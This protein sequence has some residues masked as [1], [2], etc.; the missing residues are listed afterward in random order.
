MVNIEDYNSIFNDNVNIDF[1]T[2]NEYA[3]VNNLYSSYNTTYAALTA[4]L[5]SDYML[6]TN[7]EYTNYDHFFPNIVNTKEKIKLN[8]LNFIN[9]TDYRLIHFGN[10]FYP[11]ETSPY[12]YG[13]I[14]TK[15]NF[16][17][18]LFN[19]TFFFLFEKSYLDGI[20]KKIFHKKLSQVIKKNVNFDSDDAIENL[21]FLLVNSDNKFKKTLFLVH[22]LYPHHPYVYNKKCEKKKPA[23]GNYKINYKCTLLKIKDL[24]NFLKKNDP[25]S[26]VIFISDHGLKLQVIEKKKNQTNYQVGLENFL[27][28]KKTKYEF[29]SFNLFNVPKDYRK[30]LKRNL[31]TV[32]LSRL[33][34]SIINQTE[35]EF[36]PTK[37]FLLGYPGEKR[38]GKV[39]RVYFK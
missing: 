11:D 2:N 36:E 34:I 28:D 14:N 12:S 4:F 30:F 19:K 29:S 25:N 20:Y 17:N 27:I 32:N 18:K 38:F 31:D 39:E 1:L 33:I 22:H 16:S 23:T 9:K 5:T 21:K 13:V 24:Q 26:T 7:S 10:R 37:H 8:F 35:P 6:N 15:D 3:K